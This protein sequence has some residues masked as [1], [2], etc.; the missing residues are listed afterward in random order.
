MSLPAINPAL[1]TATLLAGRVL[2]SY[3]QQAPSQLAPVSAATS[4]ANGS[5]TGTVV[6]DADGKPVAY[7]AVAVLGAAG[8]VVSG[9]ACGDDGQF[10]LLGLVPGTY[11]VRVSLLGYQDLSRPGV[12][13]PASGGPVA[14]GSLRLRPAAQQLGE[15]VVV[16]RQPLVEEK[17]DRTVYHAENDQTTRGGDATDVLKRVPL[18]SVDLDGNVSLRGNQNIKVL[19]NNKPSTITANSIADGLRQ[20]PA[21]QIKTVEVITSPSARYDAEGT[22]GIINIITKSNDLRGG[23]LSLDG[24]GGTRSGTL[25]LNGSYRTGKMGFA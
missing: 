7:A 2:P 22:G 4:R 18:L 3:S 20:L 11:T 5:L 19:I 16:A 8:T 21:D 25:N 13:V 17:V 24:S 12:V 10:V 14:L 6:A 15:V 1:L 9:G 23:Q